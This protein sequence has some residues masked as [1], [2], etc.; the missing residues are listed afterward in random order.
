MDGLHPAVL[1]LIQETVSGALSHRRWV[2][3]CGALAGDADAVPV[4]IGLG[5]HELSVDI[6][7]VPTV[8]ARVRTLSLDACRATATLALGAVDAAE[9]RAIV[10]ARHGDTE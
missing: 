5:V 10:R 1:R 4:L 8:K 3:I 9:V 7:L 6:P 2:G